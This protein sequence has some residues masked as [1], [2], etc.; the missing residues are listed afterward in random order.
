MSRE[1][2]FSCGRDYFYTSHLYDALSESA[3]QGF[4]FICVNMAGPRYVRGGVCDNTAD[5]REEPMSRSDLTLSTN[6]W[7]QL[8]VGKISSW[9]NL[10]HSSKKVRESHEKA[11]YE[12]LSYATHLSIPAV[13]VE[14]NSSDCENLSSSLVAYLQQTN[15]HVWVKVPLTYPLNK[16]YSFNIE[17]VGRED[18]WEWWTKFYALCGCNKKISVVLEIGTRCVEAMVIDRWTGEP[19]KAYSVSTESFSSNQKGFPVLNKSTQSVINSLFKLNCQGILTGTNHVNKLMGIT[20]Y[21]QY[22]QH[23]WSIRDN[24]SPVREFARGYEDFLQCPLQPLQDNLESQTYE[25]FEK[26]PVKYVRYEEAV[27][28]ALLDIKERETYQGKDVVVMVVGA[29]RGPL[30]KGTISASKATG[31]SVKIFAVEKNPNAIIT[32][33]NLNIKEWNSLV[34]IVSSDMRLWTPPELADIIVSELLGSFGDNELSPEC[35]DGAQHLLK[36][37]AISIPTSY[38]SFLAPVSST[39]L[40]NALANCVDPSKPAEAPYETPYVVY[41]H[42]VYLPAP[43]KPLFTFTHPNLQQNSNERY[44]QLQFEFSQ[45]SVIHGFVGYFSSNLYKDIT[46]SI[47]PTTYSIGMFSWFPMYFP[48]RQPLYV[49]YADRVLVNFW[50]RVGK[51]KV[52]YEW[53]VSSPR[54]SGVHNS[55]GKC[56]SIGL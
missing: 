33:R 38:T 49:E 44:T 17:E 36:P 24:E 43:C 55:G 6:D 5:K 26:D 16:E 1:A 25:M 28:Q 27:K 20:T 30:V 23:L 40:Y 18:P 52:W 13:L 42:N 53:S 35:L 45:N 34:T 14:L 8:I 37:D 7:N 41:L 10:E 32:L 21:I 3:G 54:A 9:I 56:Y 51:N 48:I 2:K 29:G 22:L 31:I 39:K 15:Q 19:V 11:F 12:E 46:I 4:D 50:R 47:H